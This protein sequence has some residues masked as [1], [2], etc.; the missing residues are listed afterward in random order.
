MYHLI[1]LRLTREEWAHCEKFSHN[2]S[3]GKNVYWSVV[4]RRPQ[5]NFWCSVPPRTHI[6]CE[7]WSSVDLLGQA[8]Q[9]IWNR[10]FSKW[11]TMRGIYFN[12]PKISYFYC[13]MVTKQILRLQI[14][15]KVIMFVHVGKTL[16]RLKK[17]V[18]DDVLGEK[19]APF[20][21]QLI[22]ILV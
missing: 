20:L 14:S 5:Q 2:C 21:H 4:V 9:H 18:P 17:N 16:Q 11:K 15:V 7:R 22:N 13:L 3:H 1:S 12:L 8:E 6:I 19:F 10:L